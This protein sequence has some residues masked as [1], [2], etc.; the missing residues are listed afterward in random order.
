MNKIRESIEFI[1]GQ[2]KRSV[3]RFPVTLGI[4]ALFM[5]V[6]IMLNH[7]G[8]TGDNT[9]QLERL[10]F[11]LAIG[12]PMS[13]AAT[14]AIERFNLSGI[15]MALVHVGAIVMTGIYYLTIPAETNVY[16]GMRFMALWSILFLAFL[17]VPY[18]YKR[19]GLSRYVLYL[20][21]RF[22]LTVFFAGAIFGGIAM[23]IFTIDELFSVSW[24]DEIYMDLFIVISSAFAV[25]HFLGSVPEMDQE[26]DVIDYSK[27]FKSLFLFIVLPIVSVYTIILYAYFV[28]MLFNF[29]LPEGIIGNLVLWY[30]LVSVIT[31]FFVRDL[32][33]EVAWLSRFMR[34]YI[35]LMIIPLIMLF[36]AIGIRINA[37][38]LTMPRYFV[39]AL[40]IFSTISLFIMWLK[41]SDTAVVTAILLMAF[42]SLT[43]FGPLSGYSM[44]LMD[45][46]NRLESLL[47]QNNMIDSNGKII[48][49]TSLGEAKEKLI[50]E[51]IDFLLD[52]YTLEE[53]A[54][55]PKNFERSNA[56]ATLGFEMSYYWP[57]ED[58]QSY[59]NYYIE[60]QTKVIPVSGADY[61]ILVSLYDKIDLTMLKD[62][63]TLEKQTNASNLEI[64]S[65]DTLLLEI[66][67]MEAAAMFYLDQTR[68]IVIESP[69]GLVTATL[70]FLSINGRINGAGEPTKVEDLDVDSY[71]VRILLNLK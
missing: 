68:N 30:A 69:D 39:V 9:K 60:E 49:N 3:Q 58:E 6:A 24:P 45:Q 42:I 38:G 57:G 55:L 17:T 53:V 15:K 13:A 48:P 70:E 5:V 47:N 1:I 12:I 59:F 67:L 11:A 20:V 21:G 8:Y 56:E 34:I 51:K 32:R 33:S 62:Q 25:T 29:R 43:F 19:E 18:F 40:A 63:V 35:P 14:L 7:A 27:I 65:A 41:K 10:I 31:L 22:F 50:S 37:Y 52:A 61:F 66:D 54:I 46:S 2:L 4:T 44:T 64:K 26:I 23:M 71:D 28:K 16:F 36:I